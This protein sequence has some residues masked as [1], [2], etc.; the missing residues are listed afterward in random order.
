MIIQAAA[1]L[2]LTAAGVPAKRPS[3]VAKLIAAVTSRISF[4][5]GIT[6]QVKRTANGEPMYLWWLSQEES[7]N[8]RGKI[9]V[10]DEFDS[11]GL[12]RIRFDMGNQDV[13]I[14]VDLKKAHAAML[15]TVGKQVQKEAARVKFK[16]RTMRDGIDKFVASCIK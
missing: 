6:A 10:I 11:S 9:E 5:F 16:S 13:V 4:A 15:G 1:R 8:S 14:P 3:P 2:N 7:D 12:L